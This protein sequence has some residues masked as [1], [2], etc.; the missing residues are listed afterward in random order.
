MT[1]LIICMNYTPIRNPIWDRS[2]EVG[3]RSK[4][5]ECSTRVISILAPPGLYSPSIKCSPLPIFFLVIS[6][7]KEICLER[8]QKVNESFQPRSDWGF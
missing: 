3:V 1:K 4:K 7:F 5:R 8:F 6:V 2:G